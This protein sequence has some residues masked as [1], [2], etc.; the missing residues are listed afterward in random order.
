MDVEEC[1]AP[2]GSYG[3]SSRLGKPL[4]PSRVRFRLN[5]SRRPVR[6]LWA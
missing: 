3:L 6:I 1:P 5:A 4:I 2:N